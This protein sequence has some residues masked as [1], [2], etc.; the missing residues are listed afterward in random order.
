MFPAHHTKE[1]LDSI[2]Q[3]TDTVILFYS[4][5]KDSIALLDM[6]AKRFKKVVVVLMYFVKGLEHIERFISFSEKNYKNIEVIQ[7]PHW[8]LTHIQKNGL[9]CSPNPKI[10]TLKLADVISSV[11]LRTGIDY[12]VLGMKQAD[13]MNRRIMLR[14]HENEAISST[15]LVYPLSKWKDSEVLRYLKNNKLP[16]PVQ[17]GNK[18]SNGAGFDIDVFLYLQKHYPN[19][20]R[21]ILDKYPLSEKLLFDYENG[22]ETI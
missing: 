15:N 1:V 10:K 9:F 13:N 3:K 19:D 11:R 18:R 14:G 5:G 2:G 21:M 16:Q 4:S 17:Y 6:L 7:V 8:C 20:L 22:L 12:V